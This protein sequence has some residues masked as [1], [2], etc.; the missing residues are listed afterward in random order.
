MLL[1]DLHQTHHELRWLRRGARAALVL[2]LALS[3]FAW[4]RAAALDRAQADARFEREAQA[5][6][7][8]VTQRVQQCMDVL[9]G[10]HAMFGVNGT[11]SRRAFHEHY[12]SLQAASR[13]PALLAV[14][15]APWVRDA[16]KPAF[17]AQT[18]ADHALLASGYPDF[19]I[20]PPGRRPHYLPVLYDEPLFSTDT[21][22]FDLAFEPARREVFERARDSG[23]AQISAPVRLLR[24]EP[25]NLGFLI[26]M[27]LYRPGAAIDT[28][29]ARRAAFVG[30]VSA[31]VNSRRLMQGA[32]SRVRE[33]NLRWTLRDRDVKAQ[34]S[35]ALP[36]VLFNDVA[37]LPDDAGH[38]SPDDTLSHTLRV[39]GRTWQ[40]TVSRPHQAPLLSPYPLA[41]L[42][43]GAMTSLGLWWALRSAAT[44]H[45]QA[46]ALGRKLSAQARSSEH[47]LR[48]VLDNTVDGIV[49]LSAQGAV[50]SVNRAACAIFRHTSEEMVGQ[51]L[52]TLVPAAASLDQGQQDMEGF[53]QDQQLSVDGVGRRL[54]GVRG[55]YSVFPLDFAVSSMTVE[56]DIQY[57]AV[58]R[59]LSAQVAAE[60]AI[61]EARR[62]LN[63]VDEMRRVIVHNAPY[64][65]F[66]LNPQGVIQAVNPAGEKLVGHRA[67]ELVGRSTTQRFFDPELVSER[68]HM[69]AM[70]LG[71]SVQQLD[72]LKHL[73][74]ESPGLP[75]E[76]TLRRADGS[77]IVTEITVTELSDESGRLSGYLAMA[78]DVTSRREAEHQLQHMAQHD[79][80]T[81]LPNRNMLQ[82]QLKTSLT[83]AER[84]G[85]HLAMMFLDIDRFK[86]IN[87]GLGHH[88]GDS[89]LVE[90]ARRLRSA[91]RTSDIVARLGGDE[92][93][94]LLPQIAAREDGERVAQKVLQLFN[95]PLRIGAHELR[96][97]PS[98]GLAIY[99]EHG[100]D[101]ITLMRH[102]DLAMYQAKSNGRNRLQVY[103]DSMLSPTADTLVLEND[104]YK[105]LERDE[106]RLH[107]QPQFDCATG[108]IQ[109]AEALVRWEHGGRL[110][111]PSDFIPLAEETGLIVAMG[112][113]VMRRACTMMQRWR[114]LTGQPLQVAVNLSAV[115]LDKQDIPALVARV[116][117]DT[118]LPATALE[119]EI[120]ESVVVR[121]SLRA[122]DI[123][124]QLRGQ[125]VAIAID[126]FGVGYSSFAYL[127]ELPVDRLKLDRSFLTSVPQST[128]DSRLV[129]AL[130]AM[131]H[132]LDVR[133]VAEGV[134]T[135]EQAS[136][137]VDHGCDTIQGYY[138]ARPMKEAD[139]EAL[140]LSQ[141]STR[142]VMPTS[143]RGVQAELALSEPGLADLNAT[144]KPVA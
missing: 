70:R 36:G 123:L 38:R 41:L 46:I 138:L 76:W 28:P 22:G 15:Y 78:H 32:A 23:E 17:E 67:Q 91:M 27:P 129:A 100:T 121:E 141:G 1:S 19:Q 21:L 26:R 96:I 71:E 8:E 97:T 58:L 51:S 6:Q 128:G 44:R 14:Q 106:L 9:A 122:A 133:I 66:V 63:E 111:P 33:A 131:G 77:F 39:G 95:E 55:D 4:W 47:Q 126:D 110:V 72:V 16:D 5:V 62:Q 13:Y 140:L 75:S 90:V 86:K 134:E 35:V 139:F 143:T 124:S 103:S 83:L 92:F 30:L 130:I 115:Q 119:L 74:Q 43:A 113:W 34:E 37:T 107:F 98:I 65:I 136:F 116:L 104:L 68:A 45:G 88:I 137:L 49:T 59:D 142:P 112:E 7:L 56:G 84:G 2:G 101:T 99:P 48:S 3:L 94:I 52:S 29:Q 114:S 102:A 12:A 24:P 11:V 31:V 53:L 79:A 50:L 118:Q 20:Q 61:A 82:D 57:I 18:R 109:G 105:A 85:H 64:A 69:L 89:V 144:D 60:H 117:H 42:L 132:R 120:T 80:L 135:P 125:G 127:R 73:A 25:D 93:V 10:F 54:S 87:D 40:L 81:S 108:R